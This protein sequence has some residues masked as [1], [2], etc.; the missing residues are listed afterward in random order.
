M[1]AGLE[2]YVLDR[3]R[4]ERLHEVADV[5]DDV[6]VSDPFDERG[7]RLL[8]EAEVL[9]THW[10]APRLDARVLDLAPNLRLVAHGAGT[11][12]DHVTDAV[13]ERGILVTSAASANARPVAEF[14]LAAIL[15]ACKDAFG[16]RERMMP[17]ADAALWPDRL[18]LVGLPRRRIGI[19][20]ASQVGRLVIELLR[21]L[22]VEVSVYDPYL[23]E[24]DAS[25]LGVTRREL[26]DLA[27]WCDVLSIHAPA[28][29]ETLHMVDATVLGALRTGATLI[30]TARGSLVDHDALV[31]ELQAG[32]ISAVLD[33]TD[34]EPLP[35]DHPLRTLPNAFVTPHV[36]GS[37]GSE[38]PVMTALA[39]DEIARFARGEP[40]RAAV[41]ATDLAR[42]A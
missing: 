11:V 1:W 15:F 8:G 29:P 22:P 21:E 16:A 7:T 35:D 3:E 18:K 27:A 14:T 40:L 26:L 25:A 23:S 10:G 4:R 17:G 41:T 38:V 28:L 34:P 19:I 42:L 6:A 20:G 33:V 5:L 13:F 39:I 30:N 36:A 31:T 24:G 9:L 12:K 32:R 2:G 37:L